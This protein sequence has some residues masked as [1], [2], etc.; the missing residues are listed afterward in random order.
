MAPDRS[1]DFAL[2]KAA[3]KEA[4]KLALGY[5]RQPLSI[6]RKADGTAVTEADFAVD[7][8]LAKKL[9]DARP[10]YGWLS[11]ESAEHE[12]RTGCR[13]VWVLDPIDGTRAFINGREDWTIALALLEG[14]IPVL[15]VVV[16]PVREEFF[17]ASAGGGAFLNGERIHPSN[18]NTLEGARIIA[19]DGV[20]KMPIW[21]TPWPALTPA[22][23]NSLAYR[24]ALVASGKIDA[25]FAITRKWEWDIAPGS[26]L[27]T[28]AGGTVTLASGK[29]LRFNTKDAKVQGFLA[30]GPKLHQMLVERLTGAE[31]NMALARRI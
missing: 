23:A 12:R 31:E 30:A 20:L 11:E 9:K 17:E 18:K 25:A 19:S 10:D 15:A 27:V 2:L 21:R 26:L 13:K 14:G 7:A 1:S 3:A 24:F 29:P 22:W 16:N 4:A 6:E 5:W 28:E 8:L